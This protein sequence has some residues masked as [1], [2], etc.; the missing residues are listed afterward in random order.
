MPLIGYSGM[1]GKIKDELLAPRLQL[2]RTLKDKL[3][4]RG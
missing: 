1:E 4:F 3:E 2:R